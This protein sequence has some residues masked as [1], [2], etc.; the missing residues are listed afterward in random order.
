VGSNGNRLQCSH[1]TPAGWPWSD[2]AGDC[3]KLPC[4]IYAHGNSGCRADGNEAI[5]CVLNDNITVLA[6][7]FAGSGLS[8]GE[9]I[10]LG[11]NEA[12]DLKACVEHLHSNGHVSLIG[13]W[14]RSM[15]SAASLIYASETPSVAGLVLDSSFSS[16]TELMMEIVAVYMPKLP[17]PLAKCI[18]FYMARVIKKRTRMDLYKLDIKKYAQSCFIPALFGHAEGDDF[19]IPRHT[20]AL[21]EVYAGDKNYVK[22]EGNHNSARPNFFYDTVS[23]FFQQVLSPPSALEMPA[24]VQTQ[25]G[26]LQPSS[27][28][29]R[30]SGRVAAGCFSRGASEDVRSTQAAEAGLEADER[31]LSAFERLGIVNMPSLRSHVAGTVDR[32]TLLESSDD[33]VEAFDWS[34]FDDIGR[35]DTLRQHGSAEDLEEAMLAQAI[36]ESLKE[37]ANSAVAPAGAGMSSTLGGAG[38]QAGGELPAGST[39]ELDGPSQAALGTDVTAVEPGP[40]VTPSE[41]G[42]QGHTNRIRDNGPDSLQLLH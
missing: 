1:Y 19:V 20:E 15:G 4:V 34:R 38:E 27:R 26:H 17:K 14:G 13:L 33:E 10:T 24:R 37:A 2:D 6:L 32:R 18:M 41:E 23:I 31:T 3:P 7:D 22:F 35:S 39:S 40:I 25:L 5:F 12:E 16:L 42:E 30:A 9:Y 8:E 36:A 11:V 21:H 29:D 28:K